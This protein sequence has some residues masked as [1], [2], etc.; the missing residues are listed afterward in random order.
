[1]GA[2]LD[3]PIGYD[4][5]EPFYDRAQVLFGVSGDRDQDTWLPPGEP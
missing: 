4:D 5:L 2:A 1:M 3:W